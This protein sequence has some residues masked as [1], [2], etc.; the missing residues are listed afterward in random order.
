MLNVNFCI[1]KF[2]PIHSSDC[3]AESRQEKGILTIL[4]LDKEI[5]VIERLGL[6]L[7]RKAVY[8]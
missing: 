7:D 6:C 3:L 8:A 5:D 2:P 1:K 4:H